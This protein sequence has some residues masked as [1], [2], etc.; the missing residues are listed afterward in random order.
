MKKNYLSVAALARLCGLVGI[1]I[2]FLASCGG[3]SAPNTPAENRA[4][5]ASA[6]ADQTVALGATVVLDGSGSTDPDGNALTYR[7]SLLERPAGSGAVLSGSTAVR[8]GFDVDTAGRYI[9][10]LVVNDGTVDSPAVTVRIDT[11][12]SAPVADAGPDQTVSLGAVVQLDGN[13][14][15]DPDGDPLTFEWEI[16]ERPTGS[17]AAV[18]NAFIAA[19]AFTADMAGAYRVSLIVSD[20]VLESTADQVVVSTANSAPVAD[21][22]PDQTALLGAMVTLDG[23]ASS[24]ADGDPLSF[25]WSLTSRPDAS[26]AELLDAAMPM[27]RFEADAEG[28]YVAQLIVNDGELDSVPD[29]T[30]VDIDVPPPVNTPPVIDST[31]VLVATVGQSYGYSV[32]ATDADN[33]PLTFGLAVAPTGMTIG[34]SSGMIAWVPDAA[35]NVVVTVQ[36]FDGRGGSDSQTYTIVVESGD[37]DGGGAGGSLPPDPVDVATE[38]DATESTT[39]YDSTAFLY[40]GTDPV[41]TGVVAGAIEPVQVAVIRGQVTTRDD[42]PLPGVVVSIKDHPEFGQ[43]L[44]RADGWF[45]LAVN[46]GGRLTVD[47]ERAGYLPSQ[48]KVAAPWQDFVVAPVVALLPLDPAVT[49]IDLATIDDIAVATGSVET[50]DDGSRQARVMFKPGTLAEMI[51]PD[52]STRPLSELNVRATEYTVGPNGPAAMPGDL[53]GN[54][55]YT[56]AVEL[57]ADEAIAAGATRVQFDRGVAFYLE[58]FLGFPTG[59]IV[60]MGYYD[61][62]KAAWIA[63]RNGRVIEIVSIDGGVASIDIDGDGVANTAEQLA[64]LGIDTAEQQRL[65]V[66]YVAGTSL[67]RVEVDHF[68]PWDCN[69]PYGPPEGAEPPRMPEPDINNI[70]VDAPCEQE[71]FST[72]ACETQV[73]GKEIELAGLEFGLHYTSKRAA[74]RRDGYQLTF[75]VTGASL[76]AAPMSGI[77]VEIAVGGRVFVERYSPAPNLVHEFTWDGNDAY[78]R[79]MTGGQPAKIRIGYTYQAVFLEPGDF[80]QSFGQFGGA[81]ISAARGRQDITSWQNFEVFVYRSTSASQ[82]LGGWSLGIHHAYDPVARMLLLG[83]GGQRSADGLTAIIEA[84]AGTG[85]LGF[86]GD[87]GPAVEATLSAPRGMAVA[88]DGSVYVV[89]DNRVRRIGT[90]GLINTIAGNGTFGSNGD[91]GLAV[92]ARL[93]GPYD[94]ALDSNGNLYIIELSARI[95]KVDTNGI[96]TTFAGT[97]EAGFSGDGGPATEAQIGRF[98]WQI[99]V[100]PDDSVYFTDND[101]NYRVRRVTPDGI[102]DTVVGDGTFTYRGDGSQA[103]ETG[104]NGQL[105]G[106]AVGADGSIYISFSN[107]HLVRRVGPDGIIRAF[108]GAQFDEGLS[109]VGGPATEARIDSPFGLALAPDGSLFVGTAVGTRE[110][111]HV[112]KVDSGGALR[113]ASGSGELGWDGNGGP[114]RDAKMRS[115]MWVAIGPDSDLYQ[116]ENGCTSCVNYWVR[117]VGPAISGYTFQDVLVA[118]E[119]GAE[120]FVFGAAGRH[121]R[122]IDANTGLAL[123]E[124]AYT[125][126]GELV[127]ITDADGRIIR[128]DRDSA[129]LATGIVAPDGP[130][131]ALLINADGYLA[132]VTNPAGQSHTLGY[133]AEGLL[134][135]HASPRSIP[136]SEYGYDSLGRLASV[137]DPAGA[138]W[139]L[140]RSDDAASNGGYTVTLT[141]PLGRMT[142]Y[143]LERLPS[144]D[145]Q[146]TITGRDGLVMTTTTVGGSSEVILP[147]GAIWRSQVRPDPRLGLAAPIYTGGMQ[148]P[149]GLQLSYE[150][151]RIADLVDSRD[152]LSLASLTETFT[153]NDRSWQTLFE[154]D[155]GTRTLTTPAGRQ[156]QELRDALGHPLE[157]RLPGLA[158]IV[159]AYDDSGRPISATQGDRAWLWTYDVAGLLATRTDP[160]SRT[161]QYF[162]DPAGRMTRKIFA[163]GSELALDYDGEGQLIGVSPPGQ[164]LHGFDISPVNQVTGYVPPELAGAGAT[165][166]VHDADRALGRI[167]WPDGTTSV[168]SYDSAGRISSFSLASGRV[169]TSYDPATGQLTG[170]VSPDGTALSQS[171]DG[172]LL[173]GSSWI[174]A[175]SGSV[176]LSWNNNLE[177]VGV[178][179]NGS[180]LP[181]TYDADGLRTGAGALSITRV[182]TTGQIQASVLGIVADEFGLNSF[183]ELASYRAGAGTDELMD[184]S[185]ER[186]ALGR[187]TQLTETVNGVTAGYSYDYDLRGR[188]VQVRLNGSVVEAYTYDSQ[189]NRLSGATGGMTR[190]AVYDTQ[191]RLTNYGG[192]SYTYD[193]HGR[194]ATRTAGAGVT[195][196]DYDEL[197]NLLQVDLPGGSTIEYVVD[198]F[199]RRVGRS[200]D[201]VLVQGLL[202]QDGLKPVAELDGSGQVISRFVYGI[203][204]HSPDYM[205]RDG[206][207]YRFIHDHRGSIRLVVDSATGEVVQ[208]ITYDSFGN[209]LADSNP[210]F[211]PFGFAGGIYDSDTGLVRFGRRDYDPEIGRWTAKDP[212]GFTGGDS[213]LYAYV[214]GDP[215]NFIDPTGEW[216][217]LCVVAAGVVAATVTGAI[218]LMPLMS[219]G[220]DG[221][222]PF[223]RRDDP[224]LRLADPNANHDELLREFRAASDELELRT[225]AAAA[226]GDAIAAGAG[227]VVGGGGFGGGWLGEKLNSWFGD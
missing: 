24:D 210:G 194:L 226:G 190:N 216:I 159:Y 22:G 120:F 4:P 155:T 223:Q 14:S 41:Q 105:T 96:I 157:Y 121:K 77:V 175:V 118:S 106:L 112:L 160:L 100:G 65:A 197:G 152:I 33:D 208:Q 154:P 131:T 3:D 63:S 25:A 59:G 32:T 42:E 138:S 145:I 170:V 90:D 193:P 174:G 97:G 44:S 177:L 184:M 169:E 80:E 29:T 149:A 143:R 125:D 123:Y 109:G 182:P 191:D 57:S 127:S 206:A 153:L 76:P 196:F 200:V 183:G 108:L 66:I 199:N 186:D 15:A 92:D 55:G 51:M 114:A 49:T 135:S 227:G 75:P 98:A 173:T 151:T 36:V 28:L 107:L 167:D 21:A 139:T 146:R 71:G 180:S 27:S 212:I 203:H 168:A 43:T 5:T 220:P 110:N 31:A 113:L 201:G 11:A 185:Y 73:L 82:S 86:S 147:D 219:S 128:I 62:E 84:H 116:T 61:R 45:D 126:A 8:A 26:A 222:D 164:P 12:N 39:V 214:G 72:I 221:R 50:D 69:W 181:M 202:Y 144:G 56:Y 161:E 171:W 217:M 34:A 150:Q 132:G 67:W 64:G 19:P 17:T 162:Y 158:P 205:V 37:G 93:E 104:L 20:G 172:P 130:R 102:I 74:G 187:I 7:W 137:L 111:Q 189:G 209:V 13:G 16:L 10:E 178:A 79:P 225:K 101:G 94:V 213:N 91:G 48:R 85:E 224:R 9:V 40:T 207:T 88:P 87:G 53:P 23:R 89:D 95:R 204:E 38:N 141:T 47:Y 176:G 124:F 134:L 78:G 156:S 136:P 198:G 215:V 35:G 6:G 188:L 165:R 117:R 81:P 133:T 192:Q 119:D 195:T 2:M 166:Y 18:S 52:G 1:A 58:N 129:G 103:L 30:T 140:N 83:T 68:T 99:A 115:P 46:G 148:T 54:V 218:P 60:P 142:N 122:T 179:V 70:P 211:Q 163:D